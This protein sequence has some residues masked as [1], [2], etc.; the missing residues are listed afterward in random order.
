LGICLS[1]TTSS[2]DFTYIALDGFVTVDNDLINN[3]SGTPTGDRG[4][5]VYIS[6][7]TAGEYDMNPPTGA[8]EVVRIIGHVINSAG[9][10]GN[11]YLIRFS[12]DNTWIEL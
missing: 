7:G 2:D 3:K 9:G 11:A 12:P 5:P 1:A 10:V 8:G 4:K 6:A